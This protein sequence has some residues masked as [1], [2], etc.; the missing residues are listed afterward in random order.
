M[1]PVSEIREPGLAGLQRAFQACVL[2]QGDALQA[3]VAD[4]PNADR[5]TRIDVYREGYALRLAEALETDFP[6]LVAVAGRR[7]FDALARAYIAAHPSRHASLRWFGRHLGT[8]LASHA[9]WKVSPALAEMA[10][11]EWAMGEAW[12]APDTTPVTAAALLALPVDAWETLSFAAIS[13]LHLLTL[14]FDVPQAWQRREQAGPQGLDVVATS[15]GPATWVVW[16]DDSKIQ[17]R[18]LEGDEA[19]VLRGLIAGESFPQLCEHLVASG[20][21]GAAAARAAGLLRAWV[22]AGM[23][24]SFTYRS[25][26]Q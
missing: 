9:P 26:D 22:E 13:S 20:D 14:W 25:T 24:G 8:F 6:G 5:R 4:G 21:E 12:D 11:F 10:H 1:S 17:Y 19:D 3:L 7:A 16:R 23:V 15:S 18:A 2:G